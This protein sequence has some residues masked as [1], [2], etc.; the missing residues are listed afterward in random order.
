ML[1]SRKRVYCLNSLFTNRRSILF[2]CR[3]E[4]RQIHL[5]F[6][7]PIAIGRPNETTCESEQDDRRR[8]EPARNDSIRVS[9]T[10]WREDEVDEHHRCDEKNRRRDGMSPWFDATKIDTNR[11]DLLH[12][13]NFCEHE[14]DGRL[15]NEQ[16]AINVNEIDA[17]VETEPLLSSPDE[18]VVRDD[19][20]ADYEF[21]GNWRHA[22]HEHPYQDD[23]KNRDVEEAGKAA[24]Q[25]PKTVR[26]IHQVRGDEE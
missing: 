11:I 18:E 24:N 22:L 3:T 1:T 10:D 26:R 14:H 25:V 4:F 19:V 8:P 16:D 5:I 6:R 15:E 7:E 21:C 2:F 9:E 23:D 17:E 12:R 20:E 13:S